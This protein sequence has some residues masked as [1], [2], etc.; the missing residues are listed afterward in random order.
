MVINLVKIKIENVVASAPLGTTLD[1]EA[2]TKVLNGEYNKERFPGIIYRVK[3]P[4]TATLLFRSGKIVCTGARSIEDIYKAISIIV[5][6]LNKA[7]FKMNKKPDITIQNIVATYDLG[8]NLNLNTIALTLGFERIEYEPEQFPGLVYRMDEPKLVLL[9]FGSG[10]IVCTGA[11]TTEDI[12]KSI[13]IIEDELK[14][15]GLI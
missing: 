11:R 1:L 7:G 13:S 14:G 8:T 4:K 6:R 9:I 3:E 10:K 2:V 5:E 12:E 15:V